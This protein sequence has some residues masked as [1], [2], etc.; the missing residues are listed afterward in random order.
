MSARVVKH[1]ADR[2][3]RQIPGF[4]IGYNYMGPQDSTPQGAFGD[5]DGR[6]VPMAAG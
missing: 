6:P 2:M 5:A 4:G 1:A 3:H